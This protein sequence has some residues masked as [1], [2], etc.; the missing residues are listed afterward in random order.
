M[1]I[2]NMFY[3]VAFQ[4]DFALLFLIPKIKSHKS[5]LVNLKFIECTTYTICVN[6]L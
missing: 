6:I 2:R 5:C 1:H 3:S 4:R